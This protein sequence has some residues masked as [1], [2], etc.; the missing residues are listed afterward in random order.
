MPIHK[1]INTGDIVGG[2]VFLNYLPSQNGMRRATYRCFCGNEF[3]NICRIISR[4]TH[5]GCGCLRKQ[6]FTKQKENT[7]IR[8]NSYKLEYECWQGIKKRCLNK[9]CKNYFLY[10]GRGISIC[11]RWQNSFNYFLT[12]MGKKP[13]V[14]HS[15][16]RIDVNGNYEPENCRW[17]TK[18][19]QANNTRVN[20]YIKIGDVTKTATQWAN[21]YNVSNFLLFG[22]LR[23]GWEPLRALT[24]NPKQN[25]NV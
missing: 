22:R 16:D 1:I 3:N 7:I 12:D 2:Y 4:G 19:E 14:H 23:R 5:N 11:K 8:I 15:I 25:K 9:K 6:M 13:T 17:A 24:T 10:G 18:I 21:I 20:K